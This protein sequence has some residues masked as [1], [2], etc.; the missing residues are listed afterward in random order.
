MLN[1]TRFSPCVCYN[2]TD[3][4][5]V[6]IGEEIPK[7]MILSS[8]VDITL[9]SAKFGLKP[10]ETQVSYETSVL[11]GSIQVEN[12]QA[13]SQRHM[14]SAQGKSQPSG[15]RVYEPANPS[16]LSLALYTPSSKENLPPQ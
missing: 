11:S 9:E 10:C 13:L 15:V 4:S 16:I 5:F 14:A 7:H 12:E 1:K 3:G 2:S 6:D 8:L